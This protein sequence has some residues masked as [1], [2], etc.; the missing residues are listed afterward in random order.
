M[1]R[2]DVHQHIVPSFWTALRERSGGD[3]SGGW[4]VPSWSQA[5][6]IDMMDDLGIATGILSPGAITFA[7]ASDARRCNEFTASVTIERPDRFG[8]F[9]ALPLPDV[10]A[11]LDEIAYAFDTLKADG[12]VLFA[13]Y[14]GTYLGDPAFA[15]VWDE[16][17]RRAAVVFIHPAQPPLPWLPGIP[18]PVVDFPLDTA[19][20]AM[21]LVVSGTM[22]RCTRTRVILAHGGGFL[23]YAA[24][25]FA[26]L[27]NEAVDPGRSVE[28]YLADMR[29]FLFD[30]A[31]CAGPA[32]M[33]SLLAFAEPGH[34]L[35]GS[36]FPFASRPVGTS[37]TRKLDA[38]VADDPG[39]A[40]NINRSAALRLFSRLG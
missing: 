32:A 35:F 2:I 37:F 8:T 13:N 3:A 4:P 40:E 25:R 11:A 15:P 28:D 10:D 34:I 20:A 39:L 19:R 1:N 24:H 6:A 22:R 27:A 23:P 5:A 36:D 21:Q 38:Y 14:R 31:L 16:L 7:N 12:V 17:D 9:A 26:E 33:P 18:G 30:T 29:R